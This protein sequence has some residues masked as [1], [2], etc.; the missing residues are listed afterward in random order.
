MFLTLQMAQQP[1]QSMFICDD[2]IMQE[3]FTS[4]G[5]L[6]LGRVLTELLQFSRFLDEGKEIQRG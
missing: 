6:V 4:M 5:P 3:D 2:K 1:P